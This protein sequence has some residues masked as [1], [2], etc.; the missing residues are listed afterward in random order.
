[1]NGWAGATARRSARRPPDVRSGLADPRPAPR[2]IA[3]RPR[4]RRG[5]ATRPSALAGQRGV[6][7][8]SSHAGGPRFGAGHA[9]VSTTLAVAGRSVPRGARR[10]R[11]RQHRA[12]T[13][14][15]IQLDPEPAPSTPTPRP[16]TEYDGT[17]VLFSPLQGTPT[18][19]N[20]FASTCT[21]CITEMPDP[22]SRPPGARRP[23]SPSSD[24][25]VPGSG[26]GPAAAHRADRGDLPDGPQDPRRLDL[27]A[28]RGPAPPDDRAARR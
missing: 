25:P 6:Q 5:T 4:H 22:E 17:E 19:I 21:P 26:E 1:M 12:R 27:P 14:A 11:R 23:R 24:S 2:S 15:T 20:F 10:R 28:P 13:M 18:L 16:F 7:V 9:Q 3:Q 8:P